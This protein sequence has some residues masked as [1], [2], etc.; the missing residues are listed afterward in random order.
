MV[1][2]FIIAIDLFRN[3]GK[4]WI[5]KATKPYYDP[6]LVKLSFEKEEIADFRE[7]LDQ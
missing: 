6:Q 4:K 7:L 3:I 5:F 2:P 1:L